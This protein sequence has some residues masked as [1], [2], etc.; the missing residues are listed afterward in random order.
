VIPR[1]DL[2]VLTRHAEP[3][4]PEVER[5][6]REQHAVDLVVHCIV[7]AARAN[8]HCRWDAIARARNEGKLRGSAPW[9]MFLDDDVVLDPQCILTLVEELDRRP[10]YA[11]LAADY[12]GES[13][14]G[15]IAGHVSMG[16][17]L[18]RRQALEQLHFSWHDTKCECQCC[19]DD[20]R[21]LHWG[22]DYCRSALARHIP[23]T[24]ICQK[25]TERERI[26]NNSIVTCMCVTRNRVPLLRRSIQCFLQQTYPDREL[27]VVYESDDEETRA[28]LA[29]LGESSVHPVEVPAD[30]RITLGTLRNIALRAGTG[31]YVAQWD[32]DD[33]HSPMRLAEQ[34]GAIQDT[35]VRG[36]LIA[37]W[38]L[39]DCRTARAYIS[40]VRPWEGS[41]VVER[42]VVPPYPD[43]PKREDTPVVEEL[44]RQ[45]QIIL[46]DQPE[47][48]IY[49]YHGMNT[50]DGN[51]WK[52]ILRRSVPLGAEMSDAVTALLN[53]ET[54]GGTILQTRQAHSIGAW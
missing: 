40:N 50:W 46:L 51:H 23:K 44:I 52:R 18:F 53:G 47:L 21:R 38:T 7:G 49:T 36:C 20:L 6:I 33:W 54:H 48:Y 8:D 29:A 28:F 26:E 1:V 4:H 32:D 41:I 14:G 25:P 11:A 12:L 13:R 24:E 37:R 22:I 35:G 39:Y 3:L 43:L 5:G 27:V 45:G 31:K 16:A 17:T 19:C 42:A 2:V 9:L 34:M 30:P 15:E 10:A